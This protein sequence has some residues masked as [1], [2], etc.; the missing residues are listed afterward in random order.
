MSTLPAITPEVIKAYQNE[1]GKSA[2]SATVKRKQISLNRFFDWATNEGH[3]PENPMTPQAQENPFVITKPKK[4]IGFKTWATIGIT[5]GLMVL[6]FM[7]TLKLQIPIPFIKSRAQE[8]I[9]QTNPGENTISGFP[10][11]SPEAATSIS[12]NSAG[13]GDWNLYA[14]LKLSDT[15]GKPQVGS[16]TLTFKLFNS[17]T[18]GTALWS[19]DP[20]NITTDNSGSALISLDGVPTELFFQNNN[21]FLEPEVGSSSAQIRIPVPTASDP[22]LPAISQDG[23]L[24]LAGASPSIKG[25]EGNLLIDGQTVTIKTTDG[26]GG[27]IEFNPDAN[28]IAHFLFEGNKGNFLNAQGPNLTSGSLYYGMVSNN[29]TGYDLIRLQSGAP[30]M[31]TRFSVSALGNTFIGGNLNVTG[32]IAT[33]GVDRLTSGGALTNITGYSQSSGNFVITQNPGD[34][35]GITKNGSAL[36]DVLTLT[37]DERPKPQYANSDYSTLVLKRYDGSTNAYALFVDEGNARF[38]GQLQLGRFD[39]NPTSIGQGSIIFNT[40]DNSLRMWNGSSWVTF[41]GSGTDADT[42]DLLDSTQFLRSDTSDNFTSGTLTTDAG[43]TLDVNGDLIVSDTS[44]AFDGANTTFAITGALTVTAGTAGNAGVVLPNDSIG[45]NEVFTTGQ[46]DEYC[47][48]YEGTGTTWEWQSCAAAGGSAWSSLTDPTADLTLAMATWNTTF[49]WDPGADSAETNF[50]LTT[51]GEDTVGSDEDQVLLALSQTSNGVDV[52]QAADALLTFANSDANDP[53]G[54]A[55]RFDAGAAGTDFTYGINFDLADIGTAEIVLENAETISNQTDGTIDF[56]ATTLASTATTVSFASAALTVSSCTGCGGGS[57]SWSGLTAPTADLTLAHTTWNTIFNW[58]PGPDSAETNFNLTTQGEDTTGG[59]DEDQVLL[60]LTQTSNGVDVTEAS[61]ALLTL[62]NNDADDP[63]NSAIRFDAGAAGTDFTYGINFDLADIGTAEIVLENAEAI[64]NQT[65]G[66]ITLE[67]DA[68]NDIALFIDQGTTGRLAISDSLQVAGLST[69]AY[70][71][72]GTTTTGHGLTTASDVLIDSALE[73]NGVLY[74]DGRTISNP[75]GTASLILPT[76]PITTAA[77]LTAQNWLVD[78]TANVGQAALIV[79]QQKAG[80]LFTASASGVTKFTIANNGNVTI[81]G[82]GTMLTVGGGTGKINVGTVDPP[83]TING[84]KYATYLSAIVGVKEET[85]GQAETSEYIP[86]VGYRFVVDFN[87]QPEGS[88]LWLFGK[89]TNIKENIQKLSALLTPA[90]PTSVWYEVDKETD[91]LLV[92]SARPTLVSYRLT[93]PRFNAD[94]YSNTRDSADT[95]PGFVINDIDIAKTINEVINVQ[96]I[97]DY[98]IEGAKTTSYILKNSAGEIVDG[99]QSV[100]NFVAG[101]IRTGALTAYEIASPKIKTSLISPLSDE[102]LA[103]RLPQDSKFLIQDS[104]AKEV[105]SIDNVGNAAF[106]GTINAKEIHSENIDSIQALLT[107]VKADQDLLTESGSW[108][109]HTATNSGALGQLAISDL[110]VTNQAAINSLS[111]S[112][113]LAIGSDFVFQS[114]DSSLNTLSSPLRI[115]S[116]AMAPV[117]IMAGLV[118]IDTEGNVM[119]AGNLN[120]AGDI[121]A[122]SYE[123]QAINPDGNS[124]ASISASGSANFKDLTV[125]GLIIGSQG[126]ATTSAQVQSGDITTNATVGRGIIPSGASEITINNLKINNYTLVYVTPTSETQNYVLYIKSKEAGKFTVGFSNPLSV[127]VN[128]NWWIVQVQ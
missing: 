66:T 112:N 13:N 83:Y 77:T 45:P 6:V 78:N 108:N 81:S 40:G 23:N 31:T 82:S 34:F 117:E 15:E 106:S 48:T 39:S 98:I 60:A 51:Q 113:S 52:T 64:H 92:Y 30:K 80:D 94:E 110:Y 127:D 54:S 43:T 5:A 118:T 37:L 10:S 20:K 14:K 62:T 46:T 65:D 70:S 74:L 2:S 32:N 114:Q 104:S 35:A 25:Q 33:G 8:S 44:I 103:V 58:D 96:K 88:D 119:I 97:S 11:P 47:L 61:D 26:G 28:G 18:G 115:Q 116:L 9:I 124:L 111:V 19:S 56:G 38:D 3:I 101:N 29:A 105:A 7:L 79:D 17:E 36:S 22:G 12:A 93:A 63:V 42:L 27:N 24:I 89:T 102:D 87:A 50:S 76:D 126:D 72:F 55:I 107:Q 71:R 84:K 67:D 75:S 122:K 100:G 57:G 53:V 128:F 91:R 121:K 95:S 86:G 1:I 125:D 16:Q 49:N 73:L 68:G 21:L 41:A 59:G 120:V 90:S 99:V 123:L 69:L 85:T 4:K 109:I